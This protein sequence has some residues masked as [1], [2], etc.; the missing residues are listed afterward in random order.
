MEKLS[1]PLYSLIRKYFILSL[2]NE[3]T[4]G[5]KRDKEKTKYVKLE[6]SYDNFFG[7][8]CSS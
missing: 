6:K 1:C 4:V 5:G 8:F 3:T 2:K 7:T